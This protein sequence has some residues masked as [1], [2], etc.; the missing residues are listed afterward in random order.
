MLRRILSAFVGLMTNAPLCLSVSFATDAVAAPVCASHSFELKYSVAITRPSWALLT[1]DINADGRDDVISQDGDPDGRDRTV[2][3]YP[4]SSSGAPGAPISVGIGPAV[5]I[6][7][8][9]PMSLG[10]FAVSKTEYAFFA[11]PAAGKDGYMQYAKR[12]VYNF[13]AIH[14][15]QVKFTYWYQ[16]VDV[17]GDGNLDLIYPRLTPDSSVEVIYGMGNGK[18]NN[19]TTL[20][21]LSGLNVGLAIARFDDFFGDG[22]QTLGVALI[23]RGQPPRS[24]ISLYSRQV[25]TFSK[26]VSC[27]VPKS[28]SFTVGPLVP[29]HLAGETLIVSMT[30][31]GKIFAL[32]LKKRQDDSSPLPYSC[33]FTQVPNGDIH[34]SATVADFNGDGNTDL[35]WRRA[36]DGQIYYTLSDPN[37]SPSQWKQMTLGVGEAISNFAA[38]DFNGDGL[39]D[40]VVKTPTRLL[41]FFS[42]CF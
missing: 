28:V 31:W 42:R 39:Q 40:I 33:S 5:P 36:S 18:F 32:S 12:G 8:A 34:E 3:M 17:N 25:G 30:G 10:R 9:A 41:Y 27:D 16:V 38:G 22:L 23:Y 13:Q 19:P 20:L 35:A 6:L 7:E 29:I 4:S 15:P 37:T 1:G 24:N 2:V 21:D 11:S 14:L 26:R